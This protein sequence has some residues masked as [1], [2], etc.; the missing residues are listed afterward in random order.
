MR[1]W[2]KIGRA[3]D[4]VLDTSM[5]YEGVRQRDFL[6]ENAKSGRDP[7]CGLRRSEQLWERLEAIEEDDS[8][9]QYAEA[10]RKIHRLPGEKPPKKNEL[11]RETRKRK[12]RHHDW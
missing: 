4:L 3:I 9:R 11:Y 12:A 7:R 1:F 2:W 8:R 5:T 10:R 6:P